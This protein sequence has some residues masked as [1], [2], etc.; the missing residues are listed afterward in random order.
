[1]MKECTVPELSVY[2]PTTAPASLT[3]EATVRTAPGTSRG[4]TPP[5]CHSQ[6]WPL[7]ELYVYSPGTAPASLTP[8]PEVPTA[9]GTWR[10]VRLPPCQRKPWSLSELSV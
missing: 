1:M 6:T 4:V 2:S 3:P 9:P 5:P 10:G 8:E 7:L